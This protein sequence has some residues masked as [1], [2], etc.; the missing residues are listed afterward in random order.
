MAE[1]AIT[2]I[3][4]SDLSPDLFVDPLTEK[5]RV[6]FPAGGVVAN[7]D[8]TYTADVGL[9][10]E[11]AVMFGPDGG[12]VLADPRDPATFVYVGI[13]S[14]AALVGQL[15]PVRTIGIMVQ[16]YWVWLPGA[17]I[18]VALDGSLTQVPPATGL[19]MIVGRAI[20]ATTVY[21]L[22]ETPIY[23]GD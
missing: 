22:P 12:V 11:R 7:G 14:A 8:P 5:L 19:S 2:V 13:T 15:V 10:G 21:L 18:F 4:P 1:T 17:P 23:E 9:S 6:N 3:T 16:T 20:N